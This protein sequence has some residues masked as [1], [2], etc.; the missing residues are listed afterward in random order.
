MLPQETYDRGSVPPSPRRGRGRGTDAAA[1]AGEERR[2]RDLHGLAHRAVCG[3]IRATG[4]EHDAQA[5]DDVRNSLGDLCDGAHA[6]GV[7][8]E[9]MLVVLKRAWREVPEA[10]RASQED[11]GVLLAQVVTLCIKEFFSPQRRR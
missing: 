2:A 7:T 10:R 11:E 1:A 8:P 3:V 4:P 6:T 5:T 9:Q